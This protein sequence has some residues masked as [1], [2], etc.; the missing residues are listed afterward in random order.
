MWVPVGK[1]DRVHS[2]APETCAVEAS[3]LT[4]DIPISANIDVENVPEA[5]NE[6]NK[7]AAEICD[8][9]KSPGQLNL[10][11]QAC[12]ETGTDFNKIRKAVCDAYSAQQRVE[13]VQV[14]IGRPL[15]DFEQ[16]IS[17]AS[18]ALYCSTW[19]PR[20]NLYSQEW[21]REGRCFHQTTDINLRR[22]WQWYEEP[23][24]YG[25][26]VKAQEH[27]RSKGLCDSHYQFTTYFVPYLSAVQL[28]GQAKR[29]GTGSVDKEAAGM[30]VTS[31]TSPCLSSLPILAKLLP[32]QLHKRNSSSDL[33]TKDDQQFGSGE[34][35]FE[36]FE[37]EQPFWRRQLFDKIKELISGVKPSNCQISGDPMNLELN[38]RDLHPASWYCVAWYPIYRIPDGKFQAA[39]L[40][41]LFG[42]NTHGLVLNC[43]AEMKAKA[44]SLPGP[45][46]P[47]EEP[48]V[49]IRGPDH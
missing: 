24:C 3:D 41:Y 16:F 7:L 18:P 26:E 1:K 21:I 20:R 48:G 5:N 2:D 49:R 36:F 4:N 12:S 39:F 10:R 34:L 23:G 6:T 13:D 30:D 32:Q 38:L 35:V 9:P 27:R 43:K 46:G 29:T 14:S 8:K 47:R 40:T 17:S 44:T 25:L 31:K 45:T 22:I 11:W 15:A 28:F 37:S 33:Q 42:T 19:P